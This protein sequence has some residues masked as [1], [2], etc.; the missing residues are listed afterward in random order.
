MAYLTFQWLSCCVIICACTIFVKYDPS[1]NS[2]LGVWELFCFIFVGFTQVSMTLVK[3]KGREQ[4]RL[5]SASAALHLQA[6]RPRTQMAFM[7]VMGWRHI[8]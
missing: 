2:V 6:K 4:R 5:Q 3:M 1:R 8:Q 7:T